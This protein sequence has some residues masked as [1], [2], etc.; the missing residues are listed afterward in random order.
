MALRI[1]AGASASASRIRIAIPRNP[2]SFYSVPHRNFT[3]KFHN[4]PPLAIRK[5]GTPIF[6][7]VGHLRN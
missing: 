3:H 6:L 5:P 2:S 4:L 7:S 1:A